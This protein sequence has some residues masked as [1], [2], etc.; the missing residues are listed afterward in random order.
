[1]IRSLVAQDMIRSLELNPRMVFRRT[2]MSLSSQSGAVGG[3]AL[4]F[5]ITAV[6]GIIVFREQCSRIVA[7]YIKVWARTLVCLIAY[8]FKPA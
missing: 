4:R 5:V 2:Y 8:L 6:V 1:M 3:N 7:L